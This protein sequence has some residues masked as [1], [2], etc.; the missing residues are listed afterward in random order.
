ME[1]LYKGF[2]H[3]FYLIIFSKQ[4]DDLV[5]RLQELEQ[6]A[7]QDAVVRERIANL[8]TEVTDPTYI[9]KVPGIL[10]GKKWI[11]GILK[12]LNYVAI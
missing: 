6:S 12:N 3:S 11:H 1:I 7:T 4:P 8:P 2:A 10:Y 5:R 9:D